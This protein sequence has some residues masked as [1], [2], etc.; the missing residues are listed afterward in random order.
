MTNYRPHQTTSD[1]RQ[2]YRTNA[3]LYKTGLDVYNVHSTATDSS[4][5]CKWSYAVICSTVQHSNHSVILL[6]VPLHVT[7]VSISGH[8]LVPGELTETMVVADHE[9]LLFSHFFTQ[10]CCVTD[11]LADIINSVVRSIMCK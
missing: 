2:L 8:H 3:R 10:F 1:S 9:K 5:S 6:R 4:F 7:Q 11:V